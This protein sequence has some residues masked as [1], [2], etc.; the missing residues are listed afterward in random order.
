MPLG[1]EVIDV[2]LDGGAVPPEKGTVP[3]FSAHVYCG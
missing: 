3:Q 2:V 1:T